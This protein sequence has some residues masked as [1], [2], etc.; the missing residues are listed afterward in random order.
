LEGKILYTNPAEAQMHGYQVED[1]IGRDV[2]IFAPPE[3]RKPMTV[4]Q[5]KQWNGSIRESINIRKD[6]SIFPVWLMSDT[7]KAADGEP[8]AIVTSCEDITRHKQAEE[9]LKR[10]RD[11]LEEL[12]KERTDELQAKNAQLQELNASKDKFFSIISHD[13]RNPF[14]TILGFTEFLENNIDRYSTHEIKH[15]VKRVRTSAEKLYALLE[16]LLTWSRLQRGVI[17]CAPVVIDLFDVAEESLAIFLPRAE[18]KQIEL[19]SVIP[20]NTLA[21]ADYTMVTTIMRNLVSNALKFTHAGGAV[22]MSAVV[23]DHQVEVV[24]TDTGCGIPP[25]GLAKLFR[26]DAT[27]T[28]IGT[29]GEQGTG[30]GLILCKELV[31]KN[32]GRI[33]VE[34]EVGQGTTFRFTIPLKPPIQE[35]KL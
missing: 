28:G 20:K 9:E 6:R 26:I 16:N 3:L 22:T 5:I 10:H 8:I 27:Y 24:V 14:T 4:E 30:L 12:V 25:D 1:L 29:D 11:H 19:R 2:G 23:Q 34:S 15:Y 35:G 18:Q 33:W 21:Y 32:G 7:V 17:K 31:E 13:L